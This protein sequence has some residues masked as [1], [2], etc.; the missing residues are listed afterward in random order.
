MRAVT[1]I[2]CGDKQGQRPHLRPQQC[3]GRT[4][5][6]GRGLRELR[7]RLRSRLRTR[8]RTAAQLRTVVRL[9]R[10][11]GY[12]QR[13]SCKPCLQ[14]PQR[15]LRQRI[16]LR[17]W[18][19]RWPASTQ[20]TQQSVRAHG[21]ACAWGSKILTHL[22][23]TRR[24]EL[25]VDYP[26]TGPRPARLR[27]ANLAATALTSSH[28]DAQSCSE[29]VRI[30]CACPS[31]WNHIVGGV[32]RFEAHQRLA[33][34]LGAHGKLSQRCAP[35]GDARSATTHAILLLSSRS[36]NK[37]HLPPAQPP[38]RTKPNTGNSLRTQ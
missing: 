17:L 37:S 12:W 33:N 34:L 29:V 30:A 11:Q 36:S 27:K 31:P 32:L 3:S 23:S 26:Q 15:Q 25:I 14:R 1:A 9:H 24:D 5:N 13:H 22:L 38:G 16:K 8:L 21:Q 19:L 2:R 4:A 20:D 28:I 10:H 35:H 7:S 6:S 18:R